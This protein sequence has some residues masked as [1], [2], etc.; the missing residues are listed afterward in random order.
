MK[1][2]SEIFLQFYLIFFYDIHKPALSFNNFHKFLH[3]WAGNLKNRLL[4]IRPVIP[5][6]HFLNFF[7]SIQILPI[8]RIFGRLFILLFSKKNLPV[9]FTDY[10]NSRF[11]CGIFGRLFIF[12]KPLLI[13]PIIRI[14]R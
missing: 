10:P 3:S 9:K 8:V 13:L 5:N 11:S 1:V 2:F 4:N 14:F 12:F 6:I 7:K